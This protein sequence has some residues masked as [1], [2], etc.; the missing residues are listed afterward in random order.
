[1]TRDDVK[2]TKGPITTYS[3]NN[4]LSKL[5]D[6]ITATNVAQADLNYATSS[7][8]GLVRFDNYTDTADN[9]AIS[10]NF[11]FDNKL[12]TGFFYNNQW[13]DTVTY[14]DATMK[15][16]TLFNNYVLMTG[17]IGIH[18][19]NSYKLNLTELFKLSENATGLKNLFHINIGSGNCV[20]A[21]SPT[22]VITTQNPQ[23]VIVSTTTQYGD[24][25]ETGLYDKIYFEWFAIGEL[26]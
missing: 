20:H 7:L 11:L 14:G 15:Y 6:Q 17:N 10:P 3:M 13:S 24:S 26:N 9:R 8:S 12:I 16:I 5:F 23:E 4:G 25:Y 21:T 19:L 22:T 2:I 18:I 1:M